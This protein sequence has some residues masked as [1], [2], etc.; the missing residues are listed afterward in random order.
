M[1][2]RLNIV[3]IGFGPVGVHAGCLHSGLWT[4]RSIIEQVIVIRLVSYFA[5]DFDYP[6]LVIYIVLLLL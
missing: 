4:Q 1:H 2:I 5:H 3:S 6:P